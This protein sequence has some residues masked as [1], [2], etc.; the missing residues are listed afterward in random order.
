MQITLKVKYSINNNKNTKMSM[1]WLSLCFHC[2]HARESKTT[3]YI[4]II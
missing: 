2:V 1:C 4:I 3:Q